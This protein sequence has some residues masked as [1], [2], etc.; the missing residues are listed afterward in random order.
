MQ[1]THKIY[2]SND[3]KEEALADDSYACMHSILEQSER[4]HKVV[5]YFVRNEQKFK[6]PMLWEE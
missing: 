4:K 3:I 1:H 2:N 6:A 5:P